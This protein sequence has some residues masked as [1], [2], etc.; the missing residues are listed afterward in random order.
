MQELQHVV[1]SS[2]FMLTDFF[3]SHS[4][5]LR[6]YTMSLSIIHKRHSDKQ[7]GIMD[8]EYSRVRPHRS[9][10]QSSLSQIQVYISKRGFQARTLCD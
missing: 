3:N 6:G 8:L 9:R 5:Q 2:G 1:L 4:G 7:A 10:Q